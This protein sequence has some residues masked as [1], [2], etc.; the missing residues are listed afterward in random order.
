MAFYEAS[1]PR[2]FAHRG[3]C[4]IGPENTVAAFDLGLRA[5]ADGL[6]LDVHLSADGEV[7][8]CH[9]ATLDRTTNATGPVAGRTAAE[10]SRVDAGWQFEDAQG[11]RPFR[12]LGIGIPSLKDVLR[13]YRD[14]PIIIELKLDTPELGR[15]VAGVVRDADAVDRV[16]GAGFGRRSIH[17]MKAALPPVATSASHPEARLELYAS[18][19][20]WANPFITYGGFQIPETAGRLR[21]VSPRFIR[22]AHKRRLQVQVWTVDEEADMDRLLAWGVDALITNRPDAAVRRRDAFLGRGT[23]L[24]G[25]P[26]VSRRV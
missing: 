22:L 15:A 23:A 6:E 3:G 7:V 9:D 14:V 25:T 16:C 19:I 11:G 2:V 26:S 8:V 13:R 10:L 4:A 1:G 21:V 17:A 12:G 24:A 5:G 20:G 18:W